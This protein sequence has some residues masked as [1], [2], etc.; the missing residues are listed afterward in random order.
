MK[1]FDTKYAILFTILVIVSIVLGLFLPDVIMVNNLFSEVIPNWLSAIGT[2]GAVVLSLYFSYSGKSVSFSP[3]IDMTVSRS[4]NVYN[5]FRISI[6]LYGFNNGKAGDAVRRISYVLSDKRHKTYNFTLYNE[7][8][9]E[10]NPESYVSLNKNI[11]T[12]DLEWSGYVL[13]DLHYLTVNIETYRNQKYALKVNPVIDMTSDIGVEKDPNQDLFRANDIF[14][15]V[16]MLKSID[17]QAT[18]ELIKSHFD[19][20]KVPDG[21][22]MIQFRFP[23]EDAELLASTYTKELKNIYL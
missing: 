10:I 12:H 16:L 3:Q 22:A 20:E 6:E 4:D 7:E 19:K 13:G 23:K 11:E 9:L 8:V 15:S 14:G 1:R 21:R 17:D 5:R 18:V 2:V